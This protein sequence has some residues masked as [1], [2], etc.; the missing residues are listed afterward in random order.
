MSAPRIN[1]NPRPGDSNYAAHVVLSH[2]MVPTLVVGGEPSF[3][4]RKI[5]PR[6]FRHGLHMV[7]H[8]PY[9]KAKGA[10]PDNIGALLVL[11]DMVGHSMSGCAVAEAEKRGIPVVMGVRK[12]A[13]LEQRL[14][15]AGFPE[16]P[17][18]APKPATSTKRPLAPDIITPSIRPLLVP[19][20]DAV[21][22]YLPEPSPSNDTENTDMP[23]PTTTEHLSN[24]TLRY[25]ARTLRELYTEAI[26]ENP[27]ITNREVYQTVLLRAA[28][29]GIEAGGERPDLLAAIRK[30]LRIIRP[31][32]AYVVKP[33]AFAAPAEPLT[34][35]PAK[36]TSTPASSDTERQHSASGDDGPY[37]SLAET[38]GQNIVRIHKPEVP[39]V[40]R[41]APSQDVRELVQMLRTAMAAEGIE[42]LTVT[43]G[44]VNFRRVVVEEGEYDV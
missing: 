28:A 27:N 20:A 43:K 8:W 35:T 13:F 2:M 22:A 6:L 40:T 32:N 30:E 18:L 23:V 16:I 3:V 38:L 24:K 39:P 37:P 11:T 19:A 21:E 15:D 31:K 26:M 17:K 41:P 1:F 4:V 33:V 5:A 36:D 25:D 44:A 12:Y 14:K 7:A 42:R 34:I 9:K 10:F 29:K